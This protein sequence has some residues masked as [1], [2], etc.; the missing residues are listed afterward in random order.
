MLSPADNDTRRY[1]AAAITAGTR[2]VPLECNPA[3]VSLGAVLIEGAPGDVVVGFA[4][5]KHTMQG[6]GAISGGTIA[7]MLDTAIA[8]AVLSA[9]QPGED[10]STISLTVNMLRRATIGGLKVQ[11]R[12]DKLG[13]R[14]AFAHGQLWNDDQVLIASATSSLAVVDVLP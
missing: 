9:L 11:A 6:N 3:F 4:A 14:V 5:G 2:N 10:C 13:R 12:V 8:V 7:A 1:I